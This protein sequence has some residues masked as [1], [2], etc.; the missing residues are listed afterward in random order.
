MRPRL[1]FLGV[2][3]IGKH[4]LRDIAES[5]MA[6][7][8]AIA[9]DSQKALS[10]A[11][12]YAPKA[13]LVT[14]YDA[15][16][17]H[18]LDAV[19]IATPS[20]LHAEQTI[21]AL[22]RGLAV[23]CQKPLGRHAG[24]TR[25]VV[26]AAARADRR[27]DVDLSYRR[28]AALAAVRELV[29]SGDLGDIYAVDLVFHN[30]YG[31]DKPWFYDRSLSGGGCLV[32]LGIHLVDAAM[33]ILGCPKIDGVTSSI[34]AG[35]ERI[36]ANT[37]AV[38]D[39]ASARLDLNTGAAVQLAC[40]WKL[41]AGRD[42]DIRMAFYGTR[43]GAAMRNVDGSFYDFVA[44]RYRGTSREQ[45]VC[46]PDAWGGRAALAWLA[47][48]SRSRA[49]SSDATGITRVAEIIDAVYAAAQPS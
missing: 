24:E 25:E 20:A 42:A 36:G 32:D 15:L 47:D 28:T 33:W 49:Y 30:A 18:G 22:E 17:E 6:D 35:G 8:V 29:V 21:R 46:G 3:W 44:E 48:I 34:F 23:F 12:A 39:F 43:G 45:V 19:V 14:S 10:E 5:R 1:G 38:E 9:D 13:A 27:L 7:I 4:R 40:S 26:A 16:L 2:G 11:Q 41:Q 31:P 37:R